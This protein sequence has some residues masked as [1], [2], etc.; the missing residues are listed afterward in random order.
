LSVL[1][2]P[3]ADPPMQDMIF[4]DWAFGNNWDDHGAKLSKKDGSCD[5][6]LAVIFKGKVGYPFQMPVRADENCNAGAPGTPGSHSSHSSAP[7]PLPLPL[8][9]QRQRDAV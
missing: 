4:K 2:T 7:L 1:F 8:P 9:D 5:F 3:Q 6:S